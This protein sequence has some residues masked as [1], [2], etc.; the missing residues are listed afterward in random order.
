MA[1]L[2]ISIPRRSMSQYANV[3]SRFLMDIK[4]LDAVQAEILKR[5]KHETPEQVALLLVQ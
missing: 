2:A 4:N 3:N 1:G 5:D